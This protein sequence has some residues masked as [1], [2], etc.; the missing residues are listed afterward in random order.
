MTT[1]NIPP[2]V[3]QIVWPILYVSLLLFIIF[4]YQQFP[5]K[6][7]T[8]TIYLFWSGIFLNLLWILL[9]FQYRQIEWSIFVL[10]VMI[11]IGFSILRINCIDKSSNK[12]DVTNFIIYT[13]YTMWLI[14]ALFLLTVNTKN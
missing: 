13:V 12:R 2:I 14:F 5:S 8:I 7:R 6:Q 1:I 11:L 3:F 9:F 4:T 10:I